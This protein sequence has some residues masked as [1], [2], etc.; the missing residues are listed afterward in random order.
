V[1]SDFT[2]QSFSGVRTTKKLPPPELWYEWQGQF[3]GRLATNYACPICDRPFTYS[4][5]CCTF[6]G[7]Q[8][9]D[10]RKIFADLYARNDIMAWT[11]SQGRWNAS[12][13]LSWNPQLGAYNLKFNAFVTKELIDILKLAIPSSDRSYEPKTKTWT[14]TESHYDFVLHLMES[15]YKTVITYSKEKIEEEYKKFQNTAAPVDP[16]TQLG[17]F[18]KLVNAAGIAIGMEE[19]DPKVARKAYLRAAMFYHPDR[20][21]ER[22]KDMSS[23]NEAWTNL[24]EYFGLRGT[25]A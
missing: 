25:T 11:D 15:K 5:Q 2:N 17:I 10:E 6:C 16:K 9:G 12:V 8:L 1:V 13:T 20:N 22:S 4:D 14:F 18:V 19:K 7:A 23:L 21:P 24:Q 3:Y